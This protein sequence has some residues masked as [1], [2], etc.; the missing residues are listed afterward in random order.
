[1][2]NFQPRSFGIIFDTHFDISILNFEYN[3]LIDIIKNEDFFLLICNGLKEEYLRQITR[4]SS[5]GYW[6]LS[7]FLDQLQR[8]NKVIIEVQPKN[9]SNN[10]I[11]N[12]KDQIHVNCA[13]CSNSKAWIIVTNDHQDF[14]WDGT[15]PPIP[16]IVDYNEF[17]NQNMRVN[18]IAQCRHFPFYP[19]K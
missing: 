17:S 7:H 4:E 6:L 9:E 5:T 3:N 15:T 8:I 18:I 2:S 11:R 10:K 12:R 16:I 14:V 13:I 19:T 1:M